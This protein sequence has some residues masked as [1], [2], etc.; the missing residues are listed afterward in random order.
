MIGRS[1]WRDGVV[2]FRVKGIAL[3]VEGGHLSGGDLDTFLISVGVQFA[4][5]RQTGRGCGDQFDD[6]QAAGQGAGPPVLRN[7][8]E[9]AVLDL[10]PLGSSGREAEIVSPVWSAKS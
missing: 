7:M 5:N 9:K 3:N 6:G 1:P 8:A 10:V 2:P 4:L